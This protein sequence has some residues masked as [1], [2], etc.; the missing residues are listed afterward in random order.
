MGPRPARIGEPWRA[1]ADGRY[2]AAFEPSV[3]S[4]L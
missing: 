4:S 1:G 2:A 3:T